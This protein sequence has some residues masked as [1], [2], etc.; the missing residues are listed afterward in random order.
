[1]SLKAL[2]KLFQ[3]VQND[4]TTEGLVEP[5]EKAVSRVKREPGF[6]F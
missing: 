4:V 1:M 3:A 6:D 5:Y 2:D